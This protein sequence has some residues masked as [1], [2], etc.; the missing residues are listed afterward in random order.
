MRGFK[1]TSGCEFIRPK[2]LGALIERQ[3][4]T[5]IL[6]WKLDLIDVKVTLAEMLTPYRNGYTKEVQTVIEE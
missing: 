3:G 2:V 6:L 4:Y 5:N 1:S